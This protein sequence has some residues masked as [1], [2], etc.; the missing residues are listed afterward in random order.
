MPK[1]V[2]PDCLVEGPAGPCNNLDVD[3]C[4]KVITLTKVNGLSDCGVTLQAVYSKLKILWKCSCDCSPCMTTPFIAYDFPMV[5]ITDEQFELVCGWDFST[6]DTCVTKLLIRDGGWARV[7]ANCVRQE[8]YMGLATLG[9]ID[10]TNGGAGCGAC[11]I[12]TGGVTIATACDTITRTCGS[13]LV[14]GFVAGGP[15]VIAASED[16]CNNGCFTILS[17]TATVITTNE[18]L[19]NTVAAPDTT[20]QFLQDGTGTAYFQQTANGSTTCINLSGPVNQAIQIAAVSSETPPGCLAF[21]ENGACPD[22]IVG[23]NCDFAGFTVPGFITI[24]SAEDAA[25]NG[26]FLVETLTVCCSTLTLNAGED[27]VANADDIA[28]RVIQETDNRNYFQIYL[29]EEQKT[30]DFYDLIICQNLTRGL[31]NKKFALPLSDGIDNKITCNDAIIDA[32]ACMLYDCITLKLYNKD[33]AQCISGCMFNYRTVIDAATNPNVNVY[34]FVQ[35][36]LRA[37][38]DI[39][40]RVCADPC[41]VPSCDTEVSAIT[42]PAQSGNITAGDY[43]IM[44]S[45]NDQ[46][47]Y[48][49]WFQVASAGCEPVLDLSTGILVDIASC[50]SACTV[51]LCVHTAMQAVVTAGSK[52]THLFDFSSAHTPCTAIATISNRQTGRTTNSLAGVG[53]TGISFC[54]ATCCEGDTATVI[55]ETQSELLNFVGCCLVT[56]TGVFIEQ[57]FAPCTNCTTHTDNCG[58]GRQFAFVS[59]GVLT[60]N[61]NLVCDGG[62]AKFFMYYTVTP[63]GC[64][65]GTCLAILVDD[66]CAVDITGTIC[67]SCVCFT[68]NYDSNTQGGRTAAPCNDPAITVVAIGLCTAQYVVATSTIQRTKTNNISIVSALER[69]YD[70]PC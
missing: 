67:T 30:Y 28:A 57:V 1:I 3:T 47:L 32:D 2:D 18:N 55:G 24:S 54:V 61:A 34:Q 22:T 36:E 60:F 45:A 40:D 65:F 70:N 19:T 39:C 51:A 7:D 44:R 53:I 23:A 17:V 33:Q 35:K 27:L 6:A 50:A 68:Y 13:W 63:C 15:L 11:N 43:F 5:S 66:G 16:A 21:N 26:T 29:R 31:V 49:V 37:T 20:A 8:E 25:N 62:P 46:R 69:N 58:I 48:H 64:N 9:A 14:D 59:T 12:I 10:T 42:F 4:M 38:V 56:S 52:N 41:P